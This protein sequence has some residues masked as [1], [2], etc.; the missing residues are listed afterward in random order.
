MQHAPKV[1]HNSIE[2]ANLASGQLKGV[3][4]GYQG[5]ISQSSALLLLSVALAL[6]NMAFSQDSDATCKPK[7]TILTC[8][9]PEK[10]PSTDSSKIAV[11]LAGAKLD[12]A[13]YCKPC[14]RDDKKSG[15]PDSD[16]A[17]EAHTEA[18]AYMTSEADNELGKPTKEK[19]RVK[20]GEKLPKKTD[21]GDLCIEYNCE[22]K[23]A[24][25]LDLNDPAVQELLEIIIELGGVIY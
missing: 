1:I 4:K 11:A 21:S 20:K 17:L 8:G 12:C 15:I 13:E 19:I 5:M 24:P 22:C 25:K 7:K 10:E 6:P 23:P 9:R 16:V 14:L 2:V 18:N 3:F